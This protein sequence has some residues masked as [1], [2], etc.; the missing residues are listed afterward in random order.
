[1]LATISVTSPKW[2]I[3]ALALSERLG[4][5]DFAARGTVR[6]ASHA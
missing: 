4:P 1:M 3:L 5:E 6:E 2:S